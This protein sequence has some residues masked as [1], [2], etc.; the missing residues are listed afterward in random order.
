MSEPAGGQPRGYV[1][2]TVL[3]FSSALAGLMLAWMWQGQSLGELGRRSQLWVDRHLTEQDTL[4]RLGVLLSG[5]DKPPAVV[6]NVSMTGSFESSAEGSPARARV[7][8]GR[9]SLRYP[10]ANEVTNYDNLFG[11]G[12]A[13][14]DPAADVLPRVNRYG[15][16]PLLGYDQEL[17]ARNAE[18]LPLTPGHV[19]VQQEGLGGPDCVS[20][21]DR[22]FPF[23]AYAPGGSIQL[24]SCYSWSNPTLEETL[25]KPERLRDKLAY[26]TGLPVVLRSRDRLEVT[27]V[28]PCARLLSQKGPVLKPKESPALAY[29]GGTWTDPYCASL[30]QQLL[31]VRQQLSQG[32]LEKAKW[33]RGKGL[34]IEGIRNLLKG[35]SGS[36]EAFFTVE[37]ACQFPIPPL[38]S[39]KEE[40]L[41][42]VLAFHVPYPADF[43]GDSQVDQSDIDELKKIHE[44]SE[45]LRK[46][47]DAL[48][49][50]VKGL[51]QKLSDLQQQLN[52]PG[53]KPED[54]QALQKQ[55]DETRQSVDSLQARIKDKNQELE[56]QDQQGQKIADRLQKER[57]RLGNNTDG[58]VP[59]SAWEDATAPVGS[60]WAY[61]QILKVLTRALFD[62]HGGDALDRIIP[63]CRLVHLGAM[64][65]AFSFSEKSLGLKG[66]VNVP[67]GKTMKLGGVDTLELEGDLWIQRGATCFVDANLTISK[68]VVWKDFKGVGASETNPKEGGEDY[69]P[70]DV[71]SEGPD[72]ST[73]P[74]YPWGRVILE[75]GA[76]L[77]VTGD[78]KVVGG[79]VDTGS[80]V[81]CSRLGGN[82]PINTA[83]LVGG[84]VKLTH[85]IY[86]GM[87]LED[88]TYR[89]A[90][91][92]SSGV[93]ALY[94]DF[95]DPFMNGVAANLCKVLGPWDQRK[96]YFARYATTFV[97]MEFLA[98]FGLAEIPF[99]IPLPV[100][101]LDRNIFEWLSTLYSVELNLTLGE[102][103][104][105]ESCGGC[106][107]AE[108]L[109][110]FSRCLRRWCSMPLPVWITRRS[111]WIRSKKHLTS[112]SKR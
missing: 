91:D 17:V 60:G 25:E 54:K 66:T 101:N 108:S 6:G 63:P 109:R 49:E 30:S 86:S 20:V 34:S 70:V 43:T 29:S 50:Q 8:W 23:A 69:E 72:G 45:R 59:Q 103:F 16:I 21:I 19:L 71:S 46:E 47:I 48:Q 102:N 32:T 26:A 89:L 2:I 83:I 93:S 28:L 81:C 90:R 98:E 105:T 1:L 80:V 73:N 75:E 65:P 106:W 9:N 87:S 38:P 10:S 42:A 11:S 15:N 12:R 67:A 95:L 77:V 44:Q 76:T 51:Q 82:R 36:F 33:I 27:G 5:P 53:L 41:V 39:F 79:N 96:S 107:A 88:L 68:A 57:D 55:I 74:L 22:A 110:C 4:A 7:R 3:G 92:S 78:L 14:Q 104:V 61:V 31:A 97:F 62:S 58:Y 100:A 18:G 13:P 111:R 85:G 24:E 99:P 37:Q 112:F 94:G 35:A 64:D 40:V 56:E 52:Q 84:D